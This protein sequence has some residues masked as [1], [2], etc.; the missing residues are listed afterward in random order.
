MVAVEKVGMGGV[1]NGTRVV[2]VVV[3]GAAGGGGGGGGRG[4]GSVVGTPRRSGARWYEG[5]DNLGLATRDT[6]IRQ[7]AVIPDE[8]TACKPARLCTR[9]TPPTSSHHMCSSTR[10]PTD[11][12]RACVRARAHTPT[13]LAHPISNPAPGSHRSHLVYNYT[14]ALRLRVAHSCSWRSS[15]R[16]FNVDD[17]HIDEVEIHLS[18]NLCSVSTRAMVSE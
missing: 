1:G 9:A 6:G 13:Q 10:S 5:H 17:S 3:G 14:R 12:T 8:R 4:M 11:H 15:E 18:P 16:G 2:G 7:L